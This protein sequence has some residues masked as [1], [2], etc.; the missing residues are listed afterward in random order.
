M[1]NLDEAIDIDPIYSFP[2]YIYKAYIYI[3]QKPENYKSLA[4]KELKNAEINISSH[5]RS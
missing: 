2:A 4:L 5:I 3:Q 1:K